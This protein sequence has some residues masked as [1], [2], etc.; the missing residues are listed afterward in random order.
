M[1]IK[2]KDRKSWTPKSFSMLEY[3]S[4]LFGKH[5][6]GAP[7]TLYFD[8]SLKA[9]LKQSN[10]FHIVILSEVFHGAQ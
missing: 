5:L 4:Q 3:S 1:L 2:K 9:T 10:Y 8:S 6:N 7:M